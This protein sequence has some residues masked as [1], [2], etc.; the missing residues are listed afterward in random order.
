VIPDEPARGGYLTADL[1]GVSGLEQ[2]RAQLDGYGALPPI[3][4]LTGMRPTSA[5][6]G[7]STFVMPA[8]GWLASHTGIVSGGIL[9]ALADG[10]LGCAI[11]STLPPATPYTTSELSMS[12]L[13]P[14]FPDG[15]DL[16]ARGRVI[17][18][19]RSLA[20]SDCVITDADGREV[21]HATSRCFVF[22]TLDPPPARPES[23]AHREPVAY[24]TPDPYLREPEG[25][26]LGTATD[27]RPGLDVWRAFVDGELPPP[28]LHHLTGAR[29]V[30]VEEGRITWTMPS[31]AWLCSPLGLVEGGMLVY[32]AD[33]AVAGACATST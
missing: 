6:P 10:P 21:A 32:L 18:A 11:Q 2:L 19:G 15:R 17:H 26:V 12:Y 30:A 4:H 22:P 8:T 13:R 27:D 5:E 23:L 1:L 29:P 9:A 33:C 16:T 24:D 3:H 28:P 25:A 14:A 31:S 7:A 20:L